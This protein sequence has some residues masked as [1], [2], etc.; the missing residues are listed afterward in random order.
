MLA[1]DDDPNEFS[2]IGHNGPI[3]RTCSA[4]FCEHCVRS[5]GGDGAVERKLNEPCEGDE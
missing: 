4:S 1:A 3:C 2:G 5:V